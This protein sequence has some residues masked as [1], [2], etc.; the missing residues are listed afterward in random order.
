MNGPESE[1]DRK[2]FLGLGLSK[3]VYV[4][5]NQTGS[6]LGQDLNLSHSNTL[7]SFRAMT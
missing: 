3:Q 5:V 4:N 7:K 6:R 2:K 1:I